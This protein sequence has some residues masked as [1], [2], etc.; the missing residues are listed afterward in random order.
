MINIFEFGAF[1]KNVYIFFFR[2]SNCVQKLGYDCKRS[3]LLNT[4]VGDSDSFSPYGWWVSRQ[5]RMMDY[6]AGSLPGKVEIILK[7]SLDLIPSPSHLV[8]IQIMGGKVCL[9]CK[10]K[11]L[12]GLVNKLLKT[13]SLSNVLP[14]NLNNF[15]RIW[16]W[17][18]WIQAIFLNLFYF[19]I[20]YEFV[21]QI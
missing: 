19:N 2:S 11:T 20:E 14:Y 16:R 10:G 3:R 7:G 4:P 12:L 8:K 18:D 1:Y 15:D 9:R 13:T 5:N 17:W 21:L 6:W